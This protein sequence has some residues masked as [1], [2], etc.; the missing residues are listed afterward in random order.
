MAAALAGIM[1]MH[2]NARMLSGQRTIAD[3]H[4]VD[5]RVAEEIFAKLVTLELRQVTLDSAI[6]AISAT[7]KIRIQYQGEQVEDGNVRVTLHAV[8]LPLHRVFDHVLA[9]TQ[10]TPV[11][12][13]RDVIALRSTRDIAERHLQDGVLLGAVTDAKT[14]RPLRG[15]KIVV[16]GVKRTETSERGTYR[17][18]VAAG[19]HAV[20]VRML[21]YVSVSRTVTINDGA[22][23]TVNIALEVSANPL[24]RVI[25]TGTV[26][27]TA[28]KAVPNAITV[29][30]AKQI[31]ERG[32]TRIDQLFRGDVPGLFAENQGSGALL[33]EVTMFSR[34]ATAISFLSAG[35]DSKIGTTNPIKT[36]V[37]GVELADPKYLSQIDPKSIERI[38]IL[39]GPQASTIYG[40]NA[41]N[42]V[43]QIFTKRGATHT[44]QLT[45]N[46]LSGWVENNFSNARTPQHDYS[47]QLSSVEGRLS[48]NAGGS[49]NYLGPWTPAKQ[50][51]RTDGFGGARLEIPTTV[52]RVTADVT[53][54]LSSTQNLQRGNAS[55]TITDY[56]QTGWYR[57]RSNT[58]LSSPTTFALAGQ[59]LGL[60]LAYAPTSWWSHELWLGQDASDAETRVT[61]R[62]Y[63]SPD[64][65]TLYLSQIHN[66][67][68]S[69]RYTA[70]ARVPVTSWMQ[71]TVTLGGDGWQ[72]LTSSWN[73]SP[74]TLTGPLMGYTSVSRQPDHNAGGFVQTQFAVH[75]QLFLTYGLRA[76]WNPGFGEKAQ[77]NY[78]PRYGVAYTQDVDMVTVKLRASY[79]QSTRPPQPTYKVV[80]TAAV[81]GFNS[82]VL[83][84]YGNFIYNFANSELTPEHQEGGE[85]GLELY[86]GT[87]GS[88]VITRYNQTVDGLIDYVKVDS[89]R[90]LVP[91]PPSDYYYVKDAAGYGYIYQYQYLNIGSIRNQGWE[92]QGSAN[93]GP[94]TTRGT[95]SWTK[96]R[97]IGVNPKYRSYFSD[98]PQYTPGATFQYLPEHTWAWG[99]T[100]DRAQST[101][102]LNVTGIGRVFTGNRDKFYL[103]HLNGSIRLQQNQLNVRSLDGAYINSNSGYALVD[104][105][106]LHRFSPRV[107]GVLQVQNLANRFT[108]DYDAEY[109]SMGRQTKGGIRVRLP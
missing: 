62:G 34:G 65:T 87:R 49:W 58:G 31:E 47:A 76:E 12:I 33:D 41:I 4:P 48:Y 91:N 79:G 99:V 102:G 1:I 103:Q 97:T 81:V 50:T 106:A 78:A 45:L 63:T 43:M 11:A 5:T 96:S 2:G 88:L 27:P 25:V 44:P 89:A 26:I 13:G 3:A 8:R 16:D 60:M 57:R 52:G 53:F 20:S 75:D 14:G 42:G 35:V 29:I 18:S 108:N 72:R 24:D 38:E 39:A 55:Q 23:E 28:L 40:S 86:F 73:V 21:G 95:Y 59:T 22:I 105:T 93:V 66:D 92:L 37:D 15:V 109:A 84:D 17:L 51:T 98:Q 10:L 54:R 7:G 77:P 19:S 6:K 46:L 56:R 107:E 32:I 74:Q 100:Y 80:Q 83:Q 85:G 70:T 9:G 69:L 64:D 90:S 71:A 30:T 67:R 61:A 36:Y 82:T 104:L 68:R 101:V 94:L